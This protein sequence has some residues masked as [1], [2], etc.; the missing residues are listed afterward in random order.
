MTTI[1]VACGFLA[2]LALPGQVNKMM[3]LKGP[4]SLV[5]TGDRTAKCLEGVAEGGASTAPAQEYTIT[6]PTIDLDWRFSER[7]PDQV[8]VIELSETQRETV[9]AAREAIRAAERAL[10]RVRHDLGDDSALVELYPDLLWINDLACGERFETTVELIGE[11][12][13]WRRRS[14]GDPCK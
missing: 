1:R 11:T 5:Q 12:A 8:K 2:A 14:L 4:C 6:A 9:R 7:T 10:L 13:L 3:E